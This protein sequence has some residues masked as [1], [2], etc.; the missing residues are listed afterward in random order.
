M[1]EKRARERKGSKRETD[2][3]RK[4]HQESLCLQMPLCQEQEK[5]IFC[6]SD[7]VDLQWLFSSLC[8]HCLSLSFVPSGVHILKAIIV[9]FDCACVCFRMDD[10]W[11]AECVGPV[12]ALVSGHFAACVC[13]FS[14]PCILPVHYCSFSWDDDVLIAGIIH[15]AGM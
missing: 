14:G 8:L 10:V 13:L 12:W 7:W 9:L 6:F 5:S 1:R 2:R 15:P 11:V 3:A 4:R